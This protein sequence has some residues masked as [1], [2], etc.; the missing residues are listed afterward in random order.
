M[1]DL[2]SVCSANGY[3]KPSIYQGQYNAL[4]R[5]CE[6]YLFPWLR[7]HNIKFYAY[8]PLAGGFL[9][10]KLTLPKMVSSAA[11]PAAESSPS[12]TDSLNSRN[13]FTGPNQ[14][15][16]ETLKLKLTRGFSFMA[17]RISFMRNVSICFRFRRYTNKLRRSHCLL[18]LGFL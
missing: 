9:T 7:E 17:F 6:K 12:V 14:C 5:S 18:N 10:G 3:V 1:R 8:S 11:S 16:I 2:L 15:C 13:R 4:F